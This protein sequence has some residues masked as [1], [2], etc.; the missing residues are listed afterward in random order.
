MAR[1]ATPGEYNSGMELDRESCYRALTTRDARFDG[2][3]FVGVTTTGVYCRPVCTARTPRRDRCQFFSRAAAAEQAGFR[4]C[5]RCRPE[6]APGHSSVDAVGRVARAAASRIEAGALDHGG[7][8][9]TL[10]SELGLGARQLRRAVARELGV[11]PI[12][13]AQTH[14]LLL[15]KQLLSETRLPITEVA[16]ASGFESLRRFNAS[17]RSHYRLAPRQLRRSVRRN[18]EAKHSRGARAGH[19]GREAPQ[20]PAAGS[21]DGE[22]L[23]LQLSYRPPLAWVE[24]LRFLAPRA[25]GGIERVDGDR[26]LRTA[27]VGRHRGWLAVSPG[28]RLNTLSVEFSAS[29]T[30]VLAPLLARLRALFDLGARPDVIA[31]QLSGDKWIGSAVRKL[32]GLRL[33][34][35]LDGFELAWRAI[36]GQQVSVRG[37][38]TLAARVA[39]RFG[40]PIKTPDPALNRM[41]PDAERLAKIDVATVRQLGIT[42]ERARAIHELARAVA[43]GELRL[44][45]GVDPQATIGQLVE[46]PGIG[47]WTAQYIAMRALSWPDAFPDRDLGL[48]HALGES[49]AA[50]LRAIAEVWRPWR[51]Y[52]VMHVWNQLAG[53][54]N[55]R[56]TCRKTK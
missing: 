33:P 16:L 26:Y 35:A 7:S 56:S 51:A 13:L 44:E 23:R 5:L 1:R 39:E 21:V 20:G 48:R 27:A 36:L 19:P 24:M 37:A 18:G 4:P 49:S 43:N 55:G 47:S 34:G 31:A 17:F 42:S 30:S 15:A 12:R 22:P 14:R 50:R 40:E 9:E 45:G 53:Q 54:T 2:L 8:L 38:S 6:L 32:P 3:F 28:K 46:L 11:S 29:L 41:T 25:I 52:G 10:A